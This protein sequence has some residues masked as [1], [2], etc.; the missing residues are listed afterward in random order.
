MKPTRRDHLRE[1]N[2]EEIKA[3]ALKQIAESGA[4]SLSLGAIA[5]EMDLTTPALYR[6]FP[7]RND[8]IA[9]LIGDAYSSFNTMLE[10]T[11][12]AISPGDHAGRFRAL[13]LA[14]HSWA[15][16]H[17][18]QYFLI[19]GNPVPG[20]KLDADVGRVADRSFLILLEVLKAAD[21]AGRIGPASQKLPLPSGLKAQL[22]AVQHGGKSYSPKVMMLALVS[23]TFIH[24][25]T[26][27]DLYQRYSL[28]LA[29]KTGEFVQLEVDRLMQSIGFE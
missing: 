29:D 27:L 1:N 9:A 4:A 22:A 11:R 24:G 19:F 26:S 14:Y 12:D 7:S 20:Y 5:R 15:V 6:Y 18:Q 13:C 3:I 21:R 16:T 10:T 17:P 2:R 28:I 23:W 25:V 8:L